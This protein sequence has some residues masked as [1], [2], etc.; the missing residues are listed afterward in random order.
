M[1]S[2]KHDLFAG[3]IV[4]PVSL[5][6]ATLSQADLKTSPRSGLALLKLVWESK[7]C[8]SGESSLK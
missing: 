8:A 6:L 1:E 3:S 4:I 2:R 7:A 5:R